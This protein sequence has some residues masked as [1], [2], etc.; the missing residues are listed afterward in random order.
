M[1]DKLVVPAA[2]EAVIQDFELTEVPFTISDIASKLEKE[3]EL[4]SI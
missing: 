4:F 3:R 1:P 2:I